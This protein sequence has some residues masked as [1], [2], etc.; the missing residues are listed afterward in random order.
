MAL[1]TQKGPRRDSA[2][3]SLL[4]SEESLVIRRD[5]ARLSLL[6]FKRE[7]THGTQDTQTDHQQHQR[8][9]QKRPSTA[10]Q[11]E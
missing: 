4:L 11:E 8:T 3:L 10:Q 1:D 6:F 2:R 7:A 5:S 9:N